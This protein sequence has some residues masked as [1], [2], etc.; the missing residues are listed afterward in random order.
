MWH[1]PPLG[2]TISLSSHAPPSLQNVYSYINFH[3]SDWKG[4][5]VE[6]GMRFAEIPLPTSC[7][8][9]EKVDVGRHQIPCGCQGLLRPSP[10]CCVTSQLRE[11]PAQLWQP[12]RPCH[13]AAGIGHPVASPAKSSKVGFF[14]GL[15]GTSTVI[16]SLNLHTGRSTK[17]VCQLPSGSHTLLPPRGL[18]GSPCS[19][20]LE[21]HGLAFLTEVFN[22]SVAGVDILAI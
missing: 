20:N 18:I 11:R 15:W 12:T 10:W 7:S 22:L 6:T 16:I 19:P 4:F 2:P 8:A 3:K 14:E 13:S 1:G 17:E 5:T 21:E 9:G